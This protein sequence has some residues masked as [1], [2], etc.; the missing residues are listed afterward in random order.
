MIR[1]QK[2]YRSSIKALRELRQAQQERE[3]KKGS[4]AAIS[5]IRAQ[6]AQLEEEVEDYQSL[7]LGLVN[8]FECDSLYDLPNML[9]RARIAR[10]MSHKDLADEIDCSESQVQRWEASDY[11]TIS[12]WRLWEIADA[13]GVSVSLKMTVADTEPRIDVALDR[14]TDYGADR[15]FVNQ[16]LVHQ[17]PSLTNSERFRILNERVR[18]VFGQDL[19]QYPSDFHG[20]LWWHNGYSGR[21][22]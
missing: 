22:G 8:T 12:A 7:S 20:R 14:L 6:I 1:N 16:R 4:D 9:I 5:S 13:L 10:G 19:D 3:V 21:D 11:E 15:S 2:E 18:F 17:D